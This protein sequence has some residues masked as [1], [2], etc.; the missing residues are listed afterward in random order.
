MHSSSH[1][2]YSPSKYKVLIVEDEYIIANN[3]EIIL[4]HAGYSVIGIANS[5]SKALNVI[6]EQRPDMVLLDIYLNGNETGIDLARHLEELNI[7]FIYISANDD[8]SVLEA[9][10]ATQPSGYI[11][12]PFRE[13][14]VLTALEIGQYRTS[15]SVELKLQ[16]ELRIQIKLTDALSAEGSWESRLANTFRLLQHQIPFDFLTIR[17]KGQ[18]GLNSF[19]YYRVSFE[20]Y[21]ILSE[22]DIARMVNFKVSQSM[23]PFFGSTVNRPTRFAQ[24][25]FHSFYMQ[26]PYWHILVKTFRLQSVFVIPLRLENGEQFEFCLFS[27]DP[28]AYLSRHQAFIERLEQPLRLTL[29]R[30][31]AYEEVKRLSEMLKQENPV[32]EHSAQTRSSFEEIVGESDSLLNVFNLVRQ[33][34][35]T[36]TTVLVTG[37]SGTGKELF[38]R[39]IHSQSSRREKVMIKVN[40]ATLPASLI[41][42]ELFGHEKGAFTGAL[43][44][45]IGKF[46][47]AHGGTIFLDEIGEMP[48]ELQAKL[49][50]VLQEKEIERIGG[51]SSVKTDVR[52]IAATNRD[53]EV[54]VREGRFRMD[55]F[56]R[57][58]TFP[59]TLPPLRERRKDIEPIAHFLAKKST[60]KQNK[61][62]LGFSATVVTELMNYSWPGN[63][64]E[65]ENVIE[66]AVILNDGKTP[67]ALGRPLLKHL[68]APDHPMSE[69]KNLK[70]YQQENSVSSKGLS[71][72]RQNQLE[73]EREYILTILN[74]TN[75]RIRGT[76]GAAELLNIRPTTLEY[77]IEKMGIRKILSVQSCG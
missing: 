19:N 10:K 54:E 27:R 65:L 16:E 61:P 13:Q 60:K 12:K 25:D 47:L 20:E 6:H 24:E 39:A 18:A 17:Y 32:V 23:Q 37:E 52:V 2:I 64:R 11:V 22:T 5:V 26:D 68:F 28:Q 1:S 53:L 50:R 42:S 48:L 40:C 31:M 15:H 76:G 34:A 66:Q 71:E 38:A 51:K 69:F 45:R 73:T 30:L 9:V 8:Q 7:A 57:L 35:P 59:L 62:F 75:G 70:E 3:L 72:I 43:E 77:R 44:K 29:E 41:E 46:E 21:Q 55:L 36:D 33:V 56:F 4:E 63:I 74:K 14:D 58:A 67:L 49:L